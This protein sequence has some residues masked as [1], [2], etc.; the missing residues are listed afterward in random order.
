M[1]KKK[2]KKADPYAVLLNSTVFQQLQEE[3]AKKIKEMKTAVTQLLADDN[4]AEAK[5]TAKEAIHWGDCMKYIETKLLNS[6]E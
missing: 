5:E 6:M 2:A 3:V 4:D 1:A